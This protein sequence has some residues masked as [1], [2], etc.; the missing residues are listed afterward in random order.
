V[1]LVVTVEITELPEAVAA[2]LQTVQTA[3]KVA[4]VAVV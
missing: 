4:M 1:D 3:V 2:L